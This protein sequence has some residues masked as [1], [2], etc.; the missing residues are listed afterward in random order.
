MKKFSTVFNQILQLLPQRE[1]EKVISDFKSDRYVKHF[2]TKALF[3]VHLFAQI[4][5]KDSL[6]DILC[7]LE[8][9]KSSWYH[10][11]IKKIA[12]STISDA[13]NRI[14]YKV[15]ERLFYQMLNKC[16]FG[17]QHQFN[18]EN[19]LYALDASTI[20]LCLSVF[21]WAKFRRAKGGIK[22][23]CLYDIK[24]QVPAFN[25]ID[26]ADIHEAKVSQN[27]DLPLIPDS[28]VTFDRAYI[29]FKQFHA[30]QTKGI[31]FVTRTKE[32]LRFGFLGQQPVPD[33]IGLQFDHV[34]Q[35]SNPQQREKYPGKLRLIGFYDHKNGKTYQFLTNNFTLAASDVAHIYKARWD[36]ELFFKWIKQNLKIKTFLGTSKNAVLSQIWVSMIYTLLLAY[37]KFQ[38]KSAYSILKLSRIFHETLFFRQHLIDLLGLRPNKVPDPTGITQLSLV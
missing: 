9:N 15:Y 30:Y 32:N 2:T 18:F 26:T 13:N 14:S 34:V 8:Q 5:K 27:A 16:Q 38:T 7:G 29:D 31:Y 21:N 23:H 33:E 10:I 28:I 25:V 36:I 37:L 22:L 17:K 24:E 3:A 12:R 35:I 11:G 20:D 4:R 6:R 1:F 19:K